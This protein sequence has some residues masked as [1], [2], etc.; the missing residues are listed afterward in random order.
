VKPLKKGQPEVAFL[1]NSIKMEK[2]NGGCAAI[3]ENSEKSH[4]E[5]V[6][7]SNGINKLRDPETSS[8]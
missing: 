3:R 6:S 1:L 4:A 8:G 7:A 2:R 5:L